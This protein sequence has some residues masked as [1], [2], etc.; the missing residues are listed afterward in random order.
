MCSSRARSCS[1]GCRCCSPRSTSCRTVKA[2]A[3]TPSSWPTSSACTRTTPRRG[4]LSCAAWRAVPARRGHRPA[5]PRLE[6][7]QGPESS[8]WPTHPCP[9][10]FVD[11]EIDHYIALPGQALGYLV[12]KQE[13]LRLRDKARSQLGADYDI[14]DFHTAI[15]DHGSLPLTVVGQVVG[16]VGGLHGSGLIGGSERRY[17]AGSPRVT[18]GRVAADTSDLLRRV[19]H[20]LRGL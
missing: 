8:R 18:R 15:L 2:G 1:R 3:C 5:L 20:P 4:M 6:P 16:Q 13:I 19:E 7:E 10:T 11:A 14:R 17:A 12:R 9:P